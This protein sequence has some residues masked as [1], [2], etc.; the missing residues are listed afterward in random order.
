MIQ[1]ADFCFSSLEFTVRVRE[2]VNRWN[3]AVN[4]APPS[5]VSGK[6]GYETRLRLGW[7]CGASSADQDSQH[8]AFRKICCQIWYG[9][10]VLHYKSCGLLDGSMRHI[11]KRIREQRRFLEYEIFWKI[12]YHSTML[13]VRYSLHKSRRPHSLHLG[14]RAVQ[15]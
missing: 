6:S 15:T 13:F 3:K 1:C 11:S 12:V 5:D 7:W 10:N 4:D 8:L 2:V 9:V 14:L